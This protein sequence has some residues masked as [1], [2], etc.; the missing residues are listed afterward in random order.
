MLLPSVTFQ[1]RRGLR[2]LSYRDCPSSTL[3]RRR[4]RRH[5]AVFPA[6]PVEFVDAGRFSPPQIRLFNLIFANRAVPPPFRTGRAFPEAQ[7]G[8][9]KSP[10]SHSRKLISPELRTKAAGCYIKVGIDDYRGYSARVRTCTG[11]GSGVSSFR[12]RNDEEKRKG[13]GGEEERST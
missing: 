10:R 4:R 9:P 2:D 8:T 12:P 13:A 3:L 6:E 7:G 5:R 1:K 11:K